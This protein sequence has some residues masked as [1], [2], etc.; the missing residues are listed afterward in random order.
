MNHRIWMV[1]EHAATLDAEGRILLPA[2]LRNL[3]NPAREEQALMATLE[4]EGGISLRSVEDW[5]RYVGTLRDRGSDGKRRRRVV[6]WLAAHSARVKCDRQ[7][8]V[9]VPD[10]LLSKA[11]VERSE[12]EKREVVV[13]GGLEQVVLWEPERW[14]E[15]CR[16]TEEVLSDDLDALVHEDEGGGDLRAVQ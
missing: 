2:P 3:L 9:R 8:R 11:G 12:E 14:A 5:D 13:V 10:G 4:P 7:G 1:G 15:F 16:V 6:M